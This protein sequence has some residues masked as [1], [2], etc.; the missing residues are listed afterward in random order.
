MLAHSSGEWIKG[1]LWMPAAKRDAQGFGSALS[2]ARRY[3]LSSTV[4]LGTDDDDGTVAVRGKPAQAPAKPAA[5]EPKPAREP[6]PRFYQGLCDRVDAAET[7]G[8]VNSVA[9]D[10]KRAAD[11]QVITGDQ[12]GVLKKA[13]AGKRTAL[14]G[15]ANGATS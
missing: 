15:T 13:V 10:A 14:G 7:V 3:C 11:N 5:A 4:G 12:L 2:Y 9:V 8:A 6:D 1:E